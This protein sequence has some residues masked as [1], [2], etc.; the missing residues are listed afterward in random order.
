MAQQLKKEQS[1][2]STF[3]FLFHTNVMLQYAEHQP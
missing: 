1:L 3:R 2:F